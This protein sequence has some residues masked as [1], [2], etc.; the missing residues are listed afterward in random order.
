MNLLDLI[1]HKE[2]KLKT[3]K[4]PLDK[5]LSIEIQEL[6]EMELPKGLKTNLPR[7][8]KIN[9][10]KLLTG[11]SIYPQEE[12]EG[13]KIYLFSRLLIET[14]EYGQR[15]SEEKLSTSFLLNREDSKQLIKMIETNLF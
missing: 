4:N 1:N 3:R 7:G 11:F 12:R 10:T 8:M 13:I 15:Y 6:E 2:H 5:T 14:K 9:K